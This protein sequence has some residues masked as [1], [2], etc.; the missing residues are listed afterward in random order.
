MD[1][2]EKLSQLHQ[3]DR[4]LSG[5]CKLNSDFLAFI[6][7]NSVSKDKK[8]KIEFLDDK[9]LIVKGFEYEAQ[10]KPRYVK[11]VR[12]EKVTLAVEYAFYVQIDDNDEKIEVFRFYL[13][14]GGRVIKSL[15]SNETLNNI[16][17]F[18]NDDVVTH[19]CCGI[20]EGIINSS[21]F[22][23]LNAIKE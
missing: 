7:E 8:S 21:L 14:D 17:D 3:F 23:P 11:Y 2:Y 18:D 5:I 13:T 19:I 9:N 15:E 6:E 10:T 12:D 16:C 22:A 1:V 4:K 20:L